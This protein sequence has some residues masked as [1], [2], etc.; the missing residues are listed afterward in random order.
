MNKSIALAFRKQAFTYRDYL[1]GPYGRLR[2]EVT[3]RRVSAF[4]EEVWEGTKVPLR[5]LDVGCGTG[6]LALR[7]AQKGYQ[8]VLLDPV[9]EMLLLA[10]EKAKAAHPLP[11][12]PP[13]ILRGSV[14]EAPDLFGE[15]AFDFAL[16]HFLLEY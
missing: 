16:C 11:L 5:T 14:E 15:G 1:E 10:E 13:R 9:E 6:E 2:Q 7:L 3:W 4:L 8:V 12:F